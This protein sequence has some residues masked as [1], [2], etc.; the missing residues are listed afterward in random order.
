MRWHGAPL[1]SAVLVPSEKKPCVRGRVVNAVTGQ[2][3]EGAQVVWATWRGAVSVRTGARGT[4]ELTVDEG[5]VGL[6]EVTAEGYYAVQP[7]WNVFPLTFAVREGTC[8]ADVVLVLV[9]RVTFVG[10]VVGPDDEPVE[11]AAITI[12]TAEEPPGPPLRSDS[13]GRFTFS[14]RDGA[15][16]V[17]R[18]QAF[19]VEVAG[20]APWTVVGHLPGIVSDAA[21]TNGEP[22]VLRVLAGAALVG[23]AQDER[24]QPVTGFSL[25]VSHAVGRS[26]W[27]A[28]KC[29]TWWTPRAA[30]R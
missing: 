19:S 20:P 25:L 18:H 8:A 4:F 23:Q 5:T 16:V 9:P 3:V 28:R 26:R 13:S 11:G 22:V 27:T 12:A 29:A 17:A 14:A 6:A 1:P 30:S 21:V 7:P 2:G 10:W 15:V 24:G